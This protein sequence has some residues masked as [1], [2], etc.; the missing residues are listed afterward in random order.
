MIIVSTI[1]ICILG[2]LLSGLFLTEKIE[3]FSLCFIL[4]LG[5][6]TLY[7]FLLNLIGIPFNL[8]SG[9]ILILLLIILVSVLSKL[10]H[11]KINRIKKFIYFG[12]MNI[13]EKILLGA[14]VFLFLSSFLGDIYWPV[15]HWD[16][17]T[18]YDFR[19]KIFVET[20]FMTEAISIGGFFGYPLMTSL[21]HTFIYLSGFSNPSFIYFFFY[22]SFVTN[23]FTN[24]KKLKLRRV[25]VLLL[26]L[27]IAISPRIFD[28]SLS[29][30]TNLPYLT[31]LV[32]GSIYLYFGI[33]NK[34]L[35]TFI[36]SALL[37]GLSTWTRSVEPFWLSSIIAAIL[38]SFM[39]RKWFW[40]VLYLLI[41][42]SVI[43]PWRFFLSYHHAGTANIANQVV[44]TASG[45]LTS[46]NIVSI[47]SSINFIIANVIYPY[48]GF[49][50][51]MSLVVLYKFIYK[52]KNWIYTAIMVI[53]LALLLGG[54]VIF[55]QNISYWQ[56]IPD[57]LTR[58]AMFI[59]PMV[60][61]LS[62][63][64]ISEFI[65]KA[66]KNENSKG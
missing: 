66:R 16:S 7:W 18:L 3:K 59:S 42:L 25:V 44:S 63:E 24:L 29:A 54:V 2:Y 27:L 32:L 31:Y 30:Y 36:L 37:I 34:D 35:G 19:S 8:L 39:N 43:L 13:L 21:S 45:L 20:G 1:A 61:F 11:K 53:D 26:T 10:I 41:F 40:P 12:N 62:A 64:A 47:I 38:F 49:F 5:V 51:L 14:I 58:M 15:R 17:L 65:P 33:K 46:L 9:F 48:S 50:L 22:I 55:S 4:G 6:F 52:S 56:D 60:I 23:F 57:S 28:H